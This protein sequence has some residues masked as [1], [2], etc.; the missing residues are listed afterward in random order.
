MP[1]FKDEISIVLEFVFRICCP[2]RLYNVISKSSEE[3]IYTIEEEGF[4]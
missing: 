4:G 1:S 2:K 3:S